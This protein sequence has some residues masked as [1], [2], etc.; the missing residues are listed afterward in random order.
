MVLLLRC[1]PKSRFNPEPP[2][3]PQALTQV[4][5]DVQALQGCWAKLRRRELA[6]LPL[7]IFGWTLIPASANRIRKHFCWQM[8]GSSEFWSTG[9]LSQQ[10]YPKPKPE[11]LTLFAKHL[12]IQDEGVQKFLTSKPPKH[13]Q[14]DVLLPG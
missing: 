2:L 3:E 4:H 11:T 9:P 7:S 14:M 1:F 5:V 6:L 8:S 10:T 12:G 13:L